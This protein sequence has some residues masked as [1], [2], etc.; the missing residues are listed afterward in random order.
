MNGAFV[1]SSY[2]DLT[3]MS[4]IEVMNK[5]ALLQSTIATQKLMPYPDRVHISDLVT[6]YFFTKKEAEDR[7]IWGFDVAGYDEW[8]STL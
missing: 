8:G 7:G 5:M 3:V 1:S 6:E 4:D 2:W